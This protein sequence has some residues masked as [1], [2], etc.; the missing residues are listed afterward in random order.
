[1]LQISHLTLT[2]RKDLRTILSDFTFVLNAGDKAVIIGE[3]GNGKSTLLKWIYDPE[4]IADYIDAEGTRTDQG[5]K[6]A[7]LP[8]ELPA[9]EQDLSVYEYFLKHE[10]FEV[11]DAS[12]LRVMAAKLGLP[13]DFY[14]SEQRM[15]TL[16]GGERIKVQMAALLLARPDILLLDEPSNDIDLETLS[17]MEEMILSFPGAV[18]FIS[19]DETLIERTANRVIL[20]E[21]LRRKTLPRATIANVPFLQFRKERADAFAKQAQLAG[22]ERREEKKA[23]ERFQRI[24]QIVEHQQNTISRGDPHGG[25]LLKRRMAKVIALERRYEREHAQM[26]EYPEEETAITIRFDRQIAMPA[27]K[28]V[29]EFQEPVL[30]APDGKTVLA[31][32]IFLQ[33]R[34]PKKVCIIGRNGVG[35]T[36]FLRQI[37]E[38]LHE[39]DNLKVCYMP[40][41]YEDLLAMNE[42]PIDY[43]APSGDK[44]EITMVRTYLGAM[45]YTADEMLH[46]IA[47]LSGGQKAKILLLKMSLSEADVL[48]LDEPTRNFS[49]LSGPQIRGILKDFSGAILSI[50]HDRKYIEEVCDTIYELTPNGLISRAS[51]Q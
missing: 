10:T 1:M 15:G 36:T 43:L 31:R 35:K 18:L 46:P 28:T 29:I 32:D 48:V 39:K 49:P 24:E 21:Q 38:T 5:E 14:Y 7:Y 34:G 23:M 8:Q 6:L 9:S 33:V 20:L 11:C 26:T 30:T 12:E 25:Y 50:S 42:T 47:E 4:L 37:V 45:K 16:S 2:H 41:N 40:Q 27:G 17:W 22:S 51:V 3:E 19:H 44:D 13:A